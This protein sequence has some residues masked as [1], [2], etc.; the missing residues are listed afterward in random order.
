[1]E[2]FL[3]QLSSGLIKALLLFLIAS[4]LSLIWGMGRVINVAHASFYVLGAFLVL[5]I[6]QLPSP[7]AVNY[8]IALL[9]APVI[10]ALIAAVMELGL[11]RRTYHRGIL[12][13][14]M[15]T[16]GMVFVF[17]G[18]IRIIWGDELHIVATPSFLRGAVSLGVVTIAKNQLPII[19][20]AP[21]TAI[22]IWAVFYRTRWGTLVRAATQDREMLGAL[23]INVPRLFTITFMMAAWLAA[24]G[25]V[26]VAPTIGLYPA[27][28][29]PLIVDAFAV[30]VIGGL[31]SILGSL[32]AA[33]II[34][35]VFAFSLLIAPELGTVLTFLI[36]AV[37]L[38]FRP[39]G[40]RGSPE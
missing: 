22:G 37:V 3:L 31:G 35:L 27:M 28:D 19:I 14:V 9:L 38:S 13:V 12:P 11:L 25:G 23:G 7:S 29:G 16:F 6:M 15:V 18:L 20:V 2:T 5:T 21:L 34:G 26:L 40:L 17:Q 10:V 39:W 30:V 32:L 1:M 8:V 36:M 33:I 4:G 24:L